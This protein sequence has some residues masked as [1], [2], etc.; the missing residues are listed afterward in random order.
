MTEILNIGNTAGT[1]GIVP[2]YE[3]N[4]RWCW[5]SLNEIFTGLQGNNRY[6]PKLNDYVID[7]ATYTTYIVDHLDPV[8]LIPTLREIRPANMSFSLTETDV[9]FGVGPGTQSDTYRLYINKSVM[10]FVMAV[11]ARLKIGGSMCSYAKI[12]K[13]PVLSGEGL[14]IS[15]VYDNTGNYI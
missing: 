7:P 4:G 3:P 14:V 12:F 8:T 13:G 9:L 11:D 1:D 10:P 5:W 2:V 6:V 15:K